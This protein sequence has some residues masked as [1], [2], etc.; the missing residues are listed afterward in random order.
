MSRLYETFTL[1]ILFN[2]PKLW[3]SE[4]LG[5]F[6]DVLLCSGI[7]S[8]IFPIYRKLVQSKGQN[9]TYIF[10]I[11]LVVFT[12]GNIGILEYFF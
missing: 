12:I 4:A 8:L 7:F 5:F 3:K 1:Y 11:L 6:Q 2:P 10:D 9:K